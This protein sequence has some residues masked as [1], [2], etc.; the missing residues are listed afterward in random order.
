MPHTSFW[1]NKSVAVTRA[2]S[3][4]SLTPPALPPLPVVSHPGYDTYL[5][6]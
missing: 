3:T 4:L 6:L 2:P 1:I 5:L